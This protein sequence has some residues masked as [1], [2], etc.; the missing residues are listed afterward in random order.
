MC[1]R[2]SQVIG[3]D[4]LLDRFN[5]QEL[6]AKVTNRYNVAPM[7]MVPIVIEENETRILRDMQWGFLPFWAKKKDGMNRPIN[8]KIETV[9]QKGMFRDSFNKYRCIIPITGFYEWRKL[10]TRKQPYYIKLKSNEIIGLAG[11]FSTWY[12]DDIVI[13][14]FAILTTEPNDL[15]RP[16]HNRM[17]V[18]LKKENEASWLSPHTE[19]NRLNELCVPFA[20]DNMEV[21]LVDSYVNSPSNDSE[22]CI[23]PL[24]NQSI[25][26][27][28]QQGLEDFF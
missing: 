27:D 6:E 12:Q 4:I 13:R 5:I 25:P 7:T 2:F 1:G 8:S 11:I 17:P 16:I 28:S 20:S 21:Y 23:V 18:I 26:E 9:A 24:E 14:S 10:E 22:E 3:V 19:V 15:I